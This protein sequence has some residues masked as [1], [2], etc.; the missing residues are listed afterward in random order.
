MSF[1]THL[2]GC[3]HRFS[4]PRID[5]DGHHYQICLACGTAFEYDWRMMRQTGRLLA[6]VVER[7]S[8]ARN[9]V[10]WSPANRA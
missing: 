10:G 5:E 2:L 4:W 8:R 7:A 1:L 6:T 9:S 3:T